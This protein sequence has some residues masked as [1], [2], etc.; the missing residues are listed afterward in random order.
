LGGGSVH[1]AHRPS[2]SPRIKQANSW[3]LVSRDWPERRLNESSIVPLRGR[4]FEP[5]SPPILVSFTGDEVRAQ[6]LTGQK[7]DGHSAVRLCWRDRASGAVLPSAG[8]PCSAGSR[9]WKT[10]LAGTL[11]GISVVAGRA[12]DFLQ[13]NKWSKP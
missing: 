10:Y 11:P 2:F 13:M 4:A 8:I 12:F 6:D 3:F 5:P 7:R 9:G 1:Q